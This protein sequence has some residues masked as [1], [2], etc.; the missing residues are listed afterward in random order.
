[1]IY[2]LRLTHQIA[3]INIVYKD[4]AH[5]THMFSIT[6]NKNTYY[7]IFFALLNNKGFFYPNREKNKGIVRNLYNQGESA[8]VEEYFS[9]LYQF[10]PLFNHLGKTILKKMW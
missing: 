8:I 9:C 7:A 4:N 2:L 10:F 3:H 6:G 5:I 1:M